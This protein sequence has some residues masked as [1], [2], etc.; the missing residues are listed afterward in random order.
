MDV[1]LSEPTSYRDYHS[2]DSE[3]IHGWFLFVPPKMQK[4]LKVAHVHV[5][6]SQE[7]SLSE[8]KLGAEGSQQFEGGIA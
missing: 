8:G 4:P 3:R 7:V 2:Q 5:C 1:Q 6:D